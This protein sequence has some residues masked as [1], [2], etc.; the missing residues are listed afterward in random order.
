MLA[1]REQFWLN[2]IFNTLVYKENT[3]NILDNAKNWLGHKH[4]ENS[5]I[6]MSLKKK[7][8]KLS[9]EH[10]KNISLGKLGDKH[11]YY[12]Q[13]RTIETKLKISLSL[14]NH[15]SLTKPLKEETKFKLSLSNS[16]IINLVDRDSNILKTF[17]QTT[18]ALKE[19]KI[20]HKKLIDFILPG[21]IRR[22]ATK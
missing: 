11:Q 19:L 9:L 14:K 22:R 3:L 8:K 17:N 13:K 20:S 16:K 21:A 15:P 18:I 10:R 6:L 4:H 2:K 1:Q 5:K 12:G 7:G